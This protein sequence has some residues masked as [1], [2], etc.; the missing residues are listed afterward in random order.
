[1]HQLIAEYKILAKKWDGRK[2]RKKHAANKWQCFSCK[3][4]YPAEGFNASSTDRKAIQECCIQ[5]G[6]WRTCIACT[7]AISIGMNPTDSPTRTCS[8]CNV[9]RTS[10]FFDGV[11]TECMVCALSVEFAEETEVRCIQCNSV[12][13]SGGTTQQRRF[14]NDRICNACAKMQ[15]ITCSICCLLYT[16][17]AADE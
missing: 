17:D 1:M 8:T 12:L 4:D 2:S 15:D 10:N 16:S 3:N 5:P 7:A 13:R 9:D 6:Y 11:A 14:G